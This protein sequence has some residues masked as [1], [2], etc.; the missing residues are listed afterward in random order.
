MNIESREGTFQILHQGQMV[1]QERDNRASAD[2][3]LKILFEYVQPS[4]MLDV[5]Y[6]LG[7]L[8]SCCPL[9]RHQ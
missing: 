5:G 8:V 6:G 3:L 2:V 7:Y 1:K 4:S 9:A